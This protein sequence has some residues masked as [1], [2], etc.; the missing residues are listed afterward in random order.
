[1]N[2]RLLLLVPALLCG[3][4]EGRTPTA[5]AEPTTRAVE[6]A[7]GGAGASAPAADAA[8]ATVG[9]KA[10]DFTLPDLDGKPV[11]LAEAKGKIVV[12]EWFN[13]ECPFVRASH[14]KG[15]LAGLAGRY[16]P[17]GVVWLAIDSSAPGRQGHDLDK[18]RAGKERYRIDYPILRD[19]SGQ[20][21]HRYA[22]TNTPHMFVID[23]RGTLVYK[24]AIDNSPDGEG[25]S[26]AGGKLVNYVAEAIDATANRQPV[27]TTETQAYG[28]TVKY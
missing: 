12:L 1:M 11:S 6:P 28:C 15:S 14:T 10:P 3:C 9:Q 4:Q 16:T 13:P 2:S 26:P 25:E 23:A 17:K 22:A 5:V 20:V 7:P 24:G 21:G 8:R 19:E 18:I 27:A